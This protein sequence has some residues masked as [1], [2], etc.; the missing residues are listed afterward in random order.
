MG[1][2]R[3]RWDG[4]SLVVEVKNF[5]EDTWLDMSGNFMSPEATVVER[6]TL[7]DADTLRYDVTID[8]PKVF[9]QAWKISMPIH[10]Q[11]VRDYGDRLLEYECVALAEEEAG[12]FVPG[13]ISEN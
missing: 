4:E 9:T 3:G 1:D 10:R 6:F 7:T 12:T 2:S 11:D 13:R 8:D 5:V